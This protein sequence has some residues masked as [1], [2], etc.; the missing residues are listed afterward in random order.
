[1]FPRWNSPYKQCDS[2]RDLVQLCSIHTLK[3]RLEIPI[4]YLFYSYNKFW[5]L[6][7]QLSSSF[8]AKVFA[9]FVFFL[10]VFF[11]FLWRVFF[12]EFAFTSCW[13]KP[14][15]CW[16]ILYLSVCHLSGIF[17]LNKS[18]ETK[19]GNCLS[20]FLS[21]ILC[22]SR[23]RLLNSSSAFLRYFSLNQSSGVL[24]IRHNTP[25]GSYWLRVGVSDGVWPDV[26]SGVRVHVRELEEKAIRSSAS[27]HLT[28]NVCRNTDSPGDIITVNFE[29]WAACHS[30]GGWVLLWFN[31]KTISQ[32]NIEANSFSI[33]FP[34]PVILHKMESLLFVAAVVVKFE[35]DV[36]RDSICHRH[37]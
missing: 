12:Y 30:A 29:S 28:G 37:E 8:R 23:H 34:L 11:L 26:I 2:I 7:W 17:P 19:E 24:N 3:I 31:C 15:Y 20:F 5:Q 25:A 4:A 22:W 18:S 35:D 36:E 16:P 14:R 6:P 10:A 27:L 9:F 1:M 32:D 13:S 33:G 21:L